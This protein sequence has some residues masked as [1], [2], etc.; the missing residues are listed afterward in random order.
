[1]NTNQFH[2]LL[3]IPILEEKNMNKKPHMGLLIMLLMFPQVVET[4]Y[5]PVLPH[6]VDYF[7]VSM[8]SAS[9][10]L[11][12][13]FMAFAVG[14]VFWGRI[15]DVIGRRKA[16]LC[17]L[18]IYAIGCLL[19]I[20]AADFNMVL[21]A[22]IISAF[23]AAVG[24]VIGQTI[25]RDSYEGKELGKVF[26]VAV[27]AVSISPVVGLMLGGFIAEYFGH[28]IVFSLLF[29]MAIML[30]AVS[31]VSLLETKPS[32]LQAVSFMSVFKAMLKDGA[33]WKSAIL[34]ACFNVMMF[35]YYSLAPFMFSQLGLSSMEFGYSGVVLAVASIFGSTLNKRLLEKEWSSQ[36]LIQVAVVF[37]M[38]GSI[39]V[40][41]YQD[42]LWFLLGMASVVAGF[43][44]AI[45]NIFSTALVNY[46][47][48]VG[49][50]GAVLGLLY[51]CLIGSG[52]GLAGVVG[53]L[54]LVLIAMSLLA[55]TILLSRE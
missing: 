19:A 17:G 12:I 13:Y 31:A 15:A 14:V 48:Q 25:L 23:G 18:L 7:G 6:L 8:A 30:L 2:I 16:M 55:G 3:S 39:Q 54:G 24:S 36:R 9:Q 10:T 49:T 5:S 43:G 28:L 41:L 21:M 52:L 42:S 37:S 22:R 50:A 51:Y 44:M 40:Y 32:Q 38:I 4:I 29:V 53:D 35:S 34:V 46:K 47:H 20:I 26:S 1:L 27:I 11:S 33:I 45:P